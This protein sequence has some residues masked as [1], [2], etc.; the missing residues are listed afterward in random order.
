METCPVKPCGI[1]KMSFDGDEMSNKMYATINGIKE[2]KTCH[3]VVKFFKMN[4][5]KKK[6]SPTAITIKNRYVGEA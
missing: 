1:K 4:E 6:K 2:M 5:S 3:Q